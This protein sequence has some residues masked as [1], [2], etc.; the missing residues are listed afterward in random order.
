[1]NFVYT[2]AI[3][4]LRAMQARKKVV[5]GGTSASKTFGI[6]AVLIDRA[7]RVPKSEISV[8]SESIPHLRRG[9]IKDFAK[10]MQAT[11]RWRDEGWN[12]TLLTYTFANGSYIEFFS[13]DQESRLR[14]ARRQVLYVNEANNIDWESY[15]QLA[16]R[17]SE[18]IYIDFNP[19]AEFWAHTEVLKDADSEL[20]I[21]TYKDNEALPATIVQEIEAAKEKGKASPYWQNW[22]RVYGEGQVGTL[23]GAIFTHWHQIDG[24][25]AGAEYVGT[26]LDF[27]FTNDPTAA[28]DAY[29]Y[30]GGVIFDEVVYDRGKF[31]NQVAEMLSTM[32][33][34]IIADAASPQNIAEIQIYLTGKGRIQAC[35]KPKG[36][37]LHAIQTLQGMPMWVTS[38]SVNLIK[39]LRSYL[40]KTD[41]T[42]A[43]L[44][45]PI[46]ANDHAMDAIVYVTNEKLGKTNNGNY[47]IR[48]PKWRN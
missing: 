8:V 12:K 34:D 22:Y 47:F 6:L 5:Q 29:R 37:K 42:G 9:A 10:I 24:I 11:N 36:H 7:A 26:G 15:Y 45:E 38:R 16:I 14:G 1:M 2:T 40:W 48:T 4:K 3:K 30:N 19:T 20:I 17:T 41:A 25:P 35:E 31:N 39:E 43:S 27:G 32:R 23:Q 18:E 13:A 44:N 28:V 46:G 21:L 33:R